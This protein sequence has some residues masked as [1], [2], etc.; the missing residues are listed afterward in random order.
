MIRCSL[1]L[2]LTVAAAYQMVMEEL[3]FCC[4]LRSWLM[5]LPRKRKDS[6]VLTGE[7]YKAWLISQSLQTGKKC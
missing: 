7:S 6:A 1:L 5:T 2:S 3:T 4:H